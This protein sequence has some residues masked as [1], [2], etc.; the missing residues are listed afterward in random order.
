MTF[1]GVEGRQTHTSDGTNRKRIRTNE[2]RANQTLNHHSKPP[3]EK[4][5]KD[6]DFLREDREKSQ[7][8]S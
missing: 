4:E 6:Y 8:V 3:F 1:G 7:F 5:I 2:S